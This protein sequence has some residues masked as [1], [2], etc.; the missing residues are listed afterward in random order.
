MKKRI[1]KLTSLILALA[2]AF[3]I[4]PPIQTNAS[5]IS[6]LFSFSVYRFHRMQENGRV[7]STFEYTWGS[8]DEEEKGLKL[9]TT[10]FDTIQVDINAQTSKLYNETKPVLMWIHKADHIFD[11]T[12]Y[13]DIDQ[14]YENKLNETFLI[15]QLE[16]TGENISI[17]AKVPMKY[18]LSFDGLIN[19]GY[20]EVEFYDKESIP[21]QLKFAYEAQVYTLEELED[22]INADMSENI[23]KY[24]NVD[25]GFRSDVDGFRFCNSDFPDGGGVCAGIAAVTTAKYNGYALNTSFTHDDEKYTITEECTWYNNVIGNDSIRN[26]EFENEFFNNNCPSLNM[27]DGSTATAYDL[28]RFYENVYENDSLLC[29]YLS[30]WKFKNNAACL[31]RG[32]SIVLGVP[33][34]NLE[35]RWSIIDYIASYLRSGKAIT[36]NICASDGG[37]S[38]VGYRMEMIDEDT[39]RLYCYDNNYPDDMVRVWKDGAEES[40]ET[41][42]DGSYKN[43]VWKDVDNQIYVDFTKVTKKIYVNKNTY[44]EVDIFTFDS[45]KTSIKTSSEKG[46]QICFSFCSGDKVGVFNYGNDANEVIAYKAFPIIKDDKTVE[47]RTFAFYKSGEAREITN[48]QYTNIKMDYSF[49]GQYKIKD[50]KVVLTKDKLTFTNQSTQYID[51]YVTYDN[52][53]ETYGQIKVRIPVKEA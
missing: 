7:K 19:G 26:I 39:Y 42:K 48:S 29:K 33:I 28:V 51:V 46:G 20:Y 22:Y 15:Q 13:T 21:E 35:N 17:D 3:S 50:S 16:Y 9:S 44:K 8:K 52:G 30:S 12:K 37:H 1:L 5:I 4:M 14:W 47:I 53:K 38:I 32:N 11:T 34:A 25:S 24:Y 27:I 40:W 6:D 43:I 10:S 23:V 18:N 36:V 31:T 2:L 41:N 49:I 45:E